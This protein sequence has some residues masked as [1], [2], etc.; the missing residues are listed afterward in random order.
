MCFGV[1][2]SLD[3]EDDFFG[4]GG[5]LFEV[6]LE[7]YEAVVLCGAVELGAVPAVAWLG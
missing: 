7:E 2:A 6:A 3:A 5:V 4:V 1:D